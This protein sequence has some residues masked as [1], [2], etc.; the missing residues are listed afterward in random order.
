MITPD[1]YKKYIKNGVI[2]AEFVPGW[3]MLAETSTEEVEF[4]EEDRTCGYATVESTPIET[5]QKEMIDLCRLTW[6]FPMGTFGEITYDG[7]KCWSIEL[8]WHNN[9]QF[10]SCIPPGIYPLK[11]CTYWGGDGPGGKRDYPTYEIG[12]VPARSLIKIHVAQH[13]KVGV[14]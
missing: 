8:P 14:K 6:D 12:S 9:A 10:I 5:I 7:Y 3:P 4:E 13:A 1:E 2:G 11:P